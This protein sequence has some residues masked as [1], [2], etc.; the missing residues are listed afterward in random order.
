MWVV[1]H[2]G[3]TH[4]I[5]MAETIFD[6]LC[7]LQTFRI[8]DWCAILAACV[9]GTLNPHAVTL[10]DGGTFIAMEMAL[11]LLVDQKERLVP[12]KTFVLVNFGKRCR[13]AFANLL[14]LY[15]S[16]MIVHMEM[17]SHGMKGSKF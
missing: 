12:A 2:Q 3:A 5:S 16:S 7:G 15:R 11:S 10:L 14:P 6:V 4:L 17:N 13:F 8:I 1:H 9:E